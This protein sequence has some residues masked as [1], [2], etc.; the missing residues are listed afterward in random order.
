MAS[1][2]SPSARDRE[3]QSCSRTV[4]VDTHQAPTVCILT[5]D[6]GKSLFQ[7]MGRQNRPPA[8][9]PRRQCRNSSAPDQQL[10][11]NNARSI[12]VFSSSAGV[13][14]M[15]RHERLTIYGEGRE[16]SV[17]RIQHWQDVASLLIGVWLVVSP[18]ALGFAGAAVWMT[19]VLGLLKSYDNSGSENRR[20]RHRPRLTPDSR[21][22]SIAPKR[23]PAVASRALLMC[24]NAVAAGSIQQVT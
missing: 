8:T 1:C 15:H 5:K 3:L 12:F 16:V 19:I 14:R 4:D 9:I 11:P 6:I 22:D 17:M 10:G 21:N 18:F 23:T 13:G 24:H 20:S 7:I 2:S